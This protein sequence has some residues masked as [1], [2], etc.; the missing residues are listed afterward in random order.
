MEISVKLFFAFVLLLL[1]HVVT[2]IITGASVSEGFNFTGWMLMFFSVMIVKLLYKLDNN[3]MVKFIK[4]VV[5]FSI[6]SL[7]CYALVQLGF[8]N[9]ISTIFRTYKSGMGTV[10]GKWLYVY[11]LRNPQRNSGVFTEPGIY[12][13]ILVMC[14]YVMVFLRDRI[15]LSNIQYNISLVILLV[16][17]VTTKSAAGF[18]GLFAIM[19]T[20]LLKR[21]KRN[22]YIIVVFMVSV[23][24][25]LVFD[26]CTN[27]YNSILEKYF[28]GKIVETAELNTNLTSGGARLVA[29]QLGIESALKHP[30]GIGFIGWQNK[31]YE[32]YGAN[33][34]T[35]NALFSQLGIR[36]FPAFFLTLYI[37]IMPATKNKKSM[38]EVSL[39]V[40]LY[41]YISIV[42]SSVLYPAVVLTAY[43]PQHLNFSGE[44]KYRSNK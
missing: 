3:V 41:I 4:V 39:Y 26:Y 19:C 5:L 15:Y 21:K 32:I 23:F 7:L 2:G 8:G 14:I 10:A 13:V 40:F 42:Q 31:L 12:Q 20:F 33:I 34:G 18:I 28:F 9:V 44:I 11:N 29:M 24:G 27:G 1:N 30:F 6:I 38:L 17:L 36:G 35:G 37:A 43:L 16:T 25:F 22:D